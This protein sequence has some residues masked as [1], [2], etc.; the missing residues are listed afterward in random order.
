MITHVELPEALA[1]V[2]TRPLF[3]MQLNVR[4]LQVLGQTPGALRRI[5]VVPGGSFQGE[6]L[7]GE[8]LE[9]G[10]DWQSVR[11]DGATTLDVRLVLKTDDAALIGLTYRGLRHGSPQIMARIEKG[12]AV[13]PASYYFRIQPLFETASPAYDWLNRVIAI[14]IGYRRADGVIYSVFEVL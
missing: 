11:T 9:G 5:G 8:V 12:E 1:S 2:R 14:G 6:R 13:D 3:V 10:S 7:R 4:P